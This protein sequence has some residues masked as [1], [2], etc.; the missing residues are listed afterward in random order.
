MSFSHPTLNLYCEINSTLFY[1]SPT[2][3][4]NRDW[5]QS[6]LSSRS[7]WC[8]THTLQNTHIHLFAVRHA[9]LEQCCGQKVKGQ[10]EYWPLT[11]LDP[12]YWYNDRTAVSTPCHR[13]VRPQINRFYHTLINLFIHR[14]SFFRNSKYNIKY[15]TFLKKII[16]R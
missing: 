4:Q 3:P 16:K 13:G 12:I 1:P 8:V 7:S 15:K 5:K 10:R 6:F 2:W 14:F 11:P 9:K